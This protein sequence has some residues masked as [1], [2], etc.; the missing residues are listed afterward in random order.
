MIPK[1][2]LTIPIFTEK[3]IEVDINSLKN[4]NF[5]VEISIARKRKNFFPEKSYTK[6]DNAIEKTKPWYVTDEP[7]SVLW[8]SKKHFFTHSK[9]QAFMQ[10]QNSYHIETSELICIARQ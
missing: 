1:E 3:N 6:N 2:W 7:I 8:D 9:K 10:V 4:W 5:N